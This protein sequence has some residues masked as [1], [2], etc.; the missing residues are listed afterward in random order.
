MSAQT[1]FSELG[2]LWIHP[3]SS[4]CNAVFLFLWSECDTCWHPSRNLGMQLLNLVEGPK[5][6]WQMGYLGPRD[7]SSSQLGLDSVLNGKRCTVKDKM[8]GYTVQFTDCGIK[9][10]KQNLQSS[11]WAA[12]IS[13]TTNITRQHLASNRVCHS[14]CLWAPTFPIH[15]VI[16]TLRFVKE[17]SACGE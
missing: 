12:F 17:C 8:K 11:N 6:G 5:S 10:I 7:L 2:W 9:P 4:L 16:Q 13:F 14:Y 3:Q 15:L 1:P